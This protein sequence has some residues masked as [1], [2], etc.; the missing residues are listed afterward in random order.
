MA[1]MTEADEVRAAID[2]I[3]LLSTQMFALLTVQVGTDLNRVELLVTQV[4]SEELVTE[5]SQ[6]E[7]LLDALKTGLW[8]FKEKVAEIRD[9]L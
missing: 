5:Q 2:K 8:N 9:R 1:S 6:L 4:G 3:D 7:P